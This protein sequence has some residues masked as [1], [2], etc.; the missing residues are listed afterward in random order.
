MIALLGLPI[1]FPTNPHLSKKL[2]NNIGGR[3]ERTWIRGSDA[4]C[5][6]WEHVDFHPDQFCCR[7]TQQRNSCPTKCVSVLQYLRVSYAPM[8]SIIVCTCRCRDCIK[9]CVLGKF[10]VI[11]IRFFFWKKHVKL[12]QA[13]WS[14]LTIIANWLQITILKE[15][16]RS[17]GGPPQILH[18][19]CA[20][21]S[22][23]IPVPP[24]SE[25]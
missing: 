14:P 23:R 25:A 17:V 13:K 12:A 5:G 6:I 10:L 24:G 7:I 15:S 1:C 21:P 3:V 20:I 16:R 11:A 18:R 19:C 2:G 4:Q 9:T 8:R 22:C